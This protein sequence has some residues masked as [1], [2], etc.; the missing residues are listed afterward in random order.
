MR[1]PTASL[2]ACSAV[3]L[4]A[5]LTG[6]GDDGN[7]PAR[8]RIEPVAAQQLASLGDEV[9][10]LAAR[11]ECAAAQRADDL[12]AAAEEARDTGRIPAALAPEVVARSQELVDELNC[13]PPPPPPP[14]PTTDEDDDDHGDGNGRGKRKKRGDDE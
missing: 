8:P 10:E 7:A 14:P 1:L 13:P 2:T 4:V 12:L 11:D 3:L 5:A 6:C 9:A